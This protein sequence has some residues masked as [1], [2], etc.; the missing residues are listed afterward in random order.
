MTTLTINETTKMLK[1]LEAIE[2]TSAKL[3]ISLD[4]SQAQWETFF[5]AHP[6]IADDLLED[7]AAYY[8]EG[9]T[10]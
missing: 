6:P 4:E 9:S 3:Q 7:M 5:E 1:T 8:L 2:A 10:G